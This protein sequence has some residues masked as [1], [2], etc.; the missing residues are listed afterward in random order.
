MPGEDDQLREVG[1]AA[2][3]LG[4]SLDP[5]GES[6]RGTL[7]A[8]ECARHRLPLAF[9]W[10]CASYPAHAGWPHNG[11]P[12]LFSPF[13]DPSQI[14]ARNEW[15][16]EDPEWPSNLVS[17]SGTDDGDYCF[18]YGGDEEPSVVYVDDWANPPADEDSPKVHAHRVADCFAGWLTGQVEWLL[19]QRERHRGGPAAG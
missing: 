11:W 7:S 9:T 12:G 5:V 19:G 16:R 3:R 10:F 15:R 14:D 18:L 17:F 8:L 6:R 1:R 4:L 2:E 13:G